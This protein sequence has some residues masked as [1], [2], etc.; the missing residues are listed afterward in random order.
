MKTL[1]ALVAAALILAGCTPDKTQEPP[2]HESPDRTNVRWIPNPSVDLMSPEGTF[3]RAA[4]ES[5]MQVWTSRKFGSEAIKEYTYPG[6]EHAFNNSRNSA[7]GGVNITHLMVGTQYFEVVNFQREGDHFIADVC[8]Y[9]SQI[10]TQ[11]EDGKYTSG[12]PQKYSSSGNSFVFGPDRSLAPEQQHPPLAHQK[13]PANRPSDNV[14]GTW[15]L[16]ESGVRKG[17]DDATQHQFLTGC[18]KPAP[19]TPDNLP[20]PY[21]RNDPP[22]TL[23]PDP[24]WPDAGN[25]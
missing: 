20:N 11:T 8:E 25:A 2:R 21:V 5:W 4:A 24:G 1:G 16:T 12:G 3:I 17:M 22:P 13:G 7:V 14:F 23:P 9:G 18:N 10:A 6:F 15:V 19:G